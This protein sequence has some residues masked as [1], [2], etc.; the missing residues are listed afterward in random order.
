MSPLVFSDR[1]SF[2]VVLLWL[3]WILDLLLRSR[4]LLIFFDAFKTRALPI[5]E[6]RSHLTVCPHG[7]YQNDFEEKLK[8][9][10]LEEEKGDVDSLREWEKSTGNHL[11]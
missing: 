9:K 11:G 1:V 5:R 4:C 7:W 8:M 6:A 10:Q 2:L 3:R